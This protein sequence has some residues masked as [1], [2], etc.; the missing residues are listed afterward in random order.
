M[1]NTKIDCGNMNPEGEEMGSLWTDLVAKINTPTTKAKVQAAIEKNKQLAIN[2]GIAQ[3]TNIIGG[4][5]AKSGATSK[6]AQDALNKVGGALYQGG[7]EGFWEANK[8]KIIVASSIL[9]LGAGF[10]IYKKY[11]K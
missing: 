1:I 10:L 2:A 7:Q 6:T 8:T 11:K 5:L 4:V 9:A 3:G